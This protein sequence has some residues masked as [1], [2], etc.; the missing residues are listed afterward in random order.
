A[1]QWQALSGD[2]HATTESAL[3]AAESGD[4]G[5]LAIM[6]QAATTLGSAIGWLANVTDPE[7]IV[8]G[9]GLG[10]AEGQWRVLLTAAIR[11][12]IWNPAAHDLPIL[13]A[14]LGSAAGWIGAALSG[15]ANDPS[16]RRREVSV[17]I[18]Q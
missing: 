17:R 6:E 8:L 10:S 2:P 3:A 5:A 16:P 11:D 14:A 12:H 9:G 7:A 4:P 15:L 1:R 18:E 13:P